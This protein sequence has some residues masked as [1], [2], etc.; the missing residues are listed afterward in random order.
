MVQEG[1]GGTPHRLGIAGPAGPGGD[2]VSRRLD[3]AG[4]GRR[5]E[6]FPRQQGGKPRHQRRHDPRGVDPAPGG[7]DLAQPEGCRDADRDKRPGGQ[8]GARVDRRKREAYRGC[9]EGA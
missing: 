1:L 9:P 8:G 3:H 4:V 7:R 6:Q 5:G 2:C